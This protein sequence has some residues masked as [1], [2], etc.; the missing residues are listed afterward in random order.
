MADSSS[1][2]SSSAG[3][4]L[5]R[6]LLLAAA[7]IAAGEAALAFTLP[8]NQGRHEGDDILAA[9]ESPQPSRPMVAWCDSVTA[10]AL[11]DAAGDPILT[12]I[13]S[14][15]AVSLAGAYFTYRRLLEVSAPPR[16]LVLGL[17]PES[18]GNDLDQVYTYTYFET[19]FVRWDE[20]RDFASTTGR[21]RMAAAMAGNRF[22][23]PPSMVR[24][25][26]V[27][28]AIQRARSLGRLDTER[29]PLF[30]VLGTDPQVLRD[31]R[32]R[33]EQKEFEFP[34]ISRLYLE[35]L[36]SA[37]E[38]TGTR[39][40]LVTAALPRPVLEGWK[41]TGYLDAYRRA[42]ESVAAGRPH[43]VVEPLDRFADFAEEDMYD[44]V[45]LK[46]E[47]VKAYGVRV[48]NRFRE[49][50]REAEAAPR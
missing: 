37:T 9:L 10:G 31:V 30:R 19:C 34:A 39:L 47:P 33:A 32:A 43:V 24:R 38:A 12:D 42:L 49:I 22:L 8:V 45:H 15:Q 16:V 25:A 7:L 17:I 40:V 20:I 35:K 29:V 36:A 14:T 1:T 48:M 2:S 5:P 41:R 50:L 6:A 3:G 13:S 28:R 23:R 44:R 27:R 11:N 26:A 18:Y 4:G 21:W 46:P